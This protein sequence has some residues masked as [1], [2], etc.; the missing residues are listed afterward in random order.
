MAF[1]KITSVPPGEAPEW[2]RE[3]WVGLVLPLLD[4]YDHAIRSRTV[5]VLSGPKSRFGYLLSRLFGQFK[6]ESGFLVESV[7]AIDLLSNTSQEAADWWRTQ[8]PELT[9]PGQI[10]MF[11]EGFGHVQTNDAP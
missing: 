4:G 7:V 11:Q 8:V 6:H 1:L 10:F 5:G 3:Q 2:V 9:R